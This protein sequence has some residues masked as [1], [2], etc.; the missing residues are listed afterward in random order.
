MKLPWKIVLHHKLY[1]VL[2]VVAALS[3]IF[4]GSLETI[5]G[6]M[7]EEAYREQRDLYG[8]FQFIAYM[9]G[10]NLK[11]N[12]FEADYVA[13]LFPDKQM[14]I[15]GYIYKLGL[16]EIDGFTVDFG[17][18]DDE[19]WRLSG[20]K[21]IKGKLP[22]SIGQI[23]LSDT[24]VSELSSAVEYDVGNEV[25]VNGRMFTIS[26]IY[27]EFGTRWVGSNSFRLY[28]EVDG[29]FSKEETEYIWNS[30]NIRLLTILMDER[31][32]F[33]NEEMQDVKNI[34]KNIYLT[35]EY[36]T[37]MYQLPEFVI[38]TVFVMSLLLMGSI[39]MLIEK[40]RTAVNKI[41]LQLGLSQGRLMV[42]QVISFLICYAF[43]LSAGILVLGTKSIRFGFQ[44]AFAMFLCV[45]AVICLRVGKGKWKRSSL[46]RGRSKAFSTGVFVLSGY[47]CVF[48]FFCILVM[49][50]E[51]HMMSIYRYKYEEE[52]LLLSSGEM[53]QIQ[54]IGYDFELLS[55]NTES[56]KNDL[57]TNSFP[58]DGSGIYFYNNY[59]YFG[60]DEDRAKEFDSMD[61]VLYTKSYK[62]NDTIMLHINGD[63][64]TDYIDASDFLK[65]GDY[66]PR[67]LQYWENSILDFYGIREELLVNSKIL[68]CQ[69][70][71]LLAIEK[72]TA[73]GRIDLDKLIS[74]EEIILVA[75]G[76]S[77]SKQ[78]GNRT[79][80]KRR[81][82]GSQDDDVY[83]D[84]S[85]AVGDV[86]TFYVLQPKDAELSFGAVSGKDVTEHFEMVKCESKVGAIINDYVGWFS[87]D[88]TAKP[89]TLIVGNKA[90]DKFGLTS[91]NTRFRIYT[92]DHADE[93][94]MTKRIYKKYRD[95]DSSMEI[96]NR[97][98][99]ERI[100]K[101][102]LSFLRTINGV[103][104]MLSAFA[105]FSILV[106]H[107]I[108]QILCEK[109]TVGMLFLNGLSQR[110]L[111]INLAKQMI[112]I[113]G[114]SMFV[115]C[116]AFYL[117]AGEEA[118]DFMWIRSMLLS[119]GLILGVQIGALAPCY[120]F[121]KKRSVVQ[122]LD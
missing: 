38:P 25:E 55:V 64:V 65:D 122:L 69:D 79:L 71:D 103:F 104:V 82:P 66:I 114:V 42:I 105:F 83:M 76:F 90:F 39:V 96:E 52:N 49:M 28:T 15:P 41:Y 102:Y 87:H 30:S 34:F 60:M 120:V 61:G 119:G 58:D 51:Y 100:H 20:G 35:E 2:A 59:M 48:I 111:F 88:R 93:S 117:M 67:T 50:W 46:K 1:W 57:I 54:D 44:S 18:L 5:S 14:K 63:K 36:A 4:P 33:S 43:G 89:Y 85:F 23:A 73:E 3:V 27:E 108:L 26:G 75:P 121:L 115:F 68:G 86:I 24:K 72:Y 62:E 13:E 74:G 10:S 29:I 32:L 17:Y 37:Y 98:R 16:A 6:N 19:A 97:M 45:V 81:L 70:E 109:K 77:L 91:T 56:P 107:I 8:S 9:D 22:D 101:T 112:R 7:S 118:G 106:I 21:M 113:W 84:E 40:Q 47:I 11:N 94:D 95:M 92:D 116:L 53:D 80:M 110:R 99:S 31:E 78:S 12:W